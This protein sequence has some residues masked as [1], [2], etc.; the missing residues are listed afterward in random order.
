MSARAAAVAMMLAA[1]LAGCKYEIFPDPQLSSKDQE[2]FAIAPQ[3]KL[4]YDPFRNR[5]RMNNNTGEPEGTIIIDSDGKFLYFV[6]SAKTMIRYPISVG[7]DE[8]LWR[9]VAT[10]KRKSEWPSWTPMSE[11]RKLNPDLPSTVPGGALNPLGARALYLHDETGKDTFI[12]IHGT[13]EPENIGMNVSLGCIRL[14]NID[15]IDLYN[16]V[17][18]GARVVAK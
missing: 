12:R 4:D 6:E 7:Q 17:P 8:Y 9:G 3:F 13:N 14:H 2:L 11:A 15:A 16:R 10:I 1:G 5:F 18:L